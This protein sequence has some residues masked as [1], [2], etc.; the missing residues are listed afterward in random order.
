MAVLMALGCAPSSTRVPPMEPAPVAAAA[1]TPFCTIDLVAPE[2]WQVTLTANDVP[3]ID[4][5]PPE[6]GEVFSLGFAHAGWWLQLDVARRSLAVGAT[7]A[8]DGQAAL[9]ALDCWEW[10]GH[11]TVDADE[12]A[13]WAVRLDAR[14]RDDEGKAVVGSF[15]GDRRR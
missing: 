13:R 14:C 11:V 6:G 5:I 12:D 4:C 9:L 10:D 3:G 2:V 15:S 7:H 1:V 8:F